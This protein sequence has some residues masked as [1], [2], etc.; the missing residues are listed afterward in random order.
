[1]SR[2]K[3]YNYL[4]E[5]IS[6]LKIYNSLTNTAEELIPIK[7]FFF[8]LSQPE[9]GLVGLTAVIH[10]QNMTLDQLPGGTTDCYAA[11]EHLILSYR[12]YTC[13]IVIYSDLTGAVDSQ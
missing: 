4:P 10:V 6:R 1:M 5:C 7:K 8:N 11:I 12:L 2:L 3:I 9:L 13:S